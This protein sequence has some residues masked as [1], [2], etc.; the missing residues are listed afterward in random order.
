MKP[1]LLA[2]T[3]V[4]STTFANANTK[5]VLDARAMTL[6]HWNPKPGTSGIGSGA[7]F[8]KAPDAAPAD[9]PRGPQDHLTR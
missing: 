4:L 7:N 5:S 3:L 8:K 9:S 2:L 6:K 1:V